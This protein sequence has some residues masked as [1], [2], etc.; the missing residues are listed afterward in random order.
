[1][2]YSNGYHERQFGGGSGRALTRAVEK[3]PIVAA[4]TAISLVASAL[5]VMYFQYGGS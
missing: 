2:P 3:H 1:M 4:G 5:V